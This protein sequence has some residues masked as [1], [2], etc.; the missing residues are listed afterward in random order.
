MSKTQMNSAKLSL[1]NSKHVIKNRHFP[2]FSKSS[3]PKLIPKTAYSAGL[4]PKV[5]LDSLF[6]YYFKNY[7][8]FIIFQKYKNSTK[9]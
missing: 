6:K 5:K 4:K 2:K 9:S 1:E 3:K 8:F 7:S